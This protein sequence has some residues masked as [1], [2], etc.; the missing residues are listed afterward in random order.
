MQSSDSEQALVKVLERLNDTISENNK[1]LLGLEDVLQTISA[2]L[3]DVAGN[4]SYGS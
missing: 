3:S 2:K 1:I 4:S